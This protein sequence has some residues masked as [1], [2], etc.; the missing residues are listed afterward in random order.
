M[1]PLT[2]K[3]MPLVSQPACVNHRFKHRTQDSS[4]MHRK[5]GRWW[6]LCSAKC[7]PNLH[8][9][10]DKQ[11]WIGKQKSKDQRHTSLDGKHVGHELRA[12]AHPADA[13]LAA[14]QILHAL[15]GRLVAG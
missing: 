14:A 1:S 9:Y 13:K 3:E 5:V 4:Q 6:V 2:A 12:T 10:N 8:V 7:Y 11:R 15:D